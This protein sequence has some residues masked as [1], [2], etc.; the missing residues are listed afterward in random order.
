MPPTLCFNLHIKDKL[1]NEPKAE[2]RKRGVDP[3]GPTRRETDAVR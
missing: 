2:E 3:K 1:E